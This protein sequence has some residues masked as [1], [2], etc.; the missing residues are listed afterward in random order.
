MRTLRCSF[1]RPC[2]CLA[3]G[4]CAC[5]KRARMSARAMSAPAPARLRRLRARR[6]ATPLAP[7][8]RHVRARRLAC[9]ADGLRVAPPVQ[10][11]AAAS[12]RARRP[13]HPR[14]LR[15]DR[16][17]RRRH[18]GHGD[19]AAVT[20]AGPPAWPRRRE[21]C[22]AVKPV[23]RAWS[24]SRSGPVGALLDPLTIEYGPVDSVLVIGAMRTKALPRR[25]RLSP[26]VHHITASPTTPA[27]THPCSTR[28]HLHRTLLTLTPP[29][30]TR[31]PLP[32]QCPCPS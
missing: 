26:R 21:A 13:P 28:L 9:F 19:P 10:A 12:G 25:R 31:S 6:G 5:C 4:R 24:S 16:Q 2:R 3:R 1:G 11:A 18:H 14:H 8:H 29:P 32:L 17:A 30:A 23:S 20:P 7:G 15:H 22:V 27:H